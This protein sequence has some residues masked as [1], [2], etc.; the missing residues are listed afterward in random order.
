M[1]SQTAVRITVSSNQKALVRKALSPFEET[2]LLPNGLTSQ[3]LADLTSIPL[4][5]MSAT[6]SKMM[7]RRQVADLL[8][9]SYKTI[10]NYEDQGVF[11]AIRLSSKQGG[12]VR[13]DSRE[14]LRFQTHGSAMSNHDISIVKTVMEGCAQ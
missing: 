7:S 6:P 5:M 12:A 10:Q 8:G 3:I 4:G 13:F 14:V 2:G 9:V 11:K 1:K